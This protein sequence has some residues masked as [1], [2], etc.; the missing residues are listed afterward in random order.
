MLEPDR[1]SQA[2]RSYVLDVLSKYWGTGRNFIYDLPIPCLDHQQE[3]LPPRMVEVALPDWANDTGINQSLLAPQQ[4]VRNGEGAEWQRTDWFRVCFW[5]LSG[6]AEKAF[7]R[8]HGPI[9]SYSFRLKGWDERIWQRAWVNRTA[10]FLRRWAA[11]EQGKRELSLFGPLPLSRVILTHDVDAVE[12]TAAIRLKQAAFN[13][14]NASRQLIRGNGSTAIQKLASAGRFLFSK[15]DY[16]CFDEILSLEESFGVRSHFNFYGGGDLRNTGF[17]Q[18]LFDPSYRLQEP[19]LTQQIRTMKR[20]GWTVGLHQSFHAWGDADMMFREKGRLEEIVGE[21]VSS[22]RQ[23]WLRFSWEKT[24]KAQQKAGFNLDTTLGFN[25]RP[26]FRNGAAIE[27]HPWDSGLNQPMKI[28]ALPMVIMDSHLYDY[29]ELEKQGR[30]E[31]MIFWLNEIRSV[32]GSATIIWHQR[33]MSRD[34]GWGAG[35]KDLLELTGV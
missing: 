18:R 5:Y 26:A 31:Q 21:C 19:R 2:V 4:F 3:Y 27:F 23:H 35:Y 12:K 28:V 29:Q 16:W 1:G 30:K 17:S 13:G 11:V 32:G 7:E 15:D 8:K 10:L 34:Y 9:H 20:N 6:E 25:D 24:W 14:F 22:C 33:V